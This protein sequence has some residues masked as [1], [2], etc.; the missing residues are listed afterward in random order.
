MGQSIQSTLM[1]ATRA[2]THTVTMIVL[3]DRI[4]QTV[5]VTARVAAIN[6]D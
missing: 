2:V 4:N 6:V 3:L 1:A 5:C